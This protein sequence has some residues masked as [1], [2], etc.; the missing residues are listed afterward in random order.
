MLDA[1]S[2][3]IKPGKER[4]FGIKKT[5]QMSGREWKYM[6]ESGLVEMGSSLMT[7]ILE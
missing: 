2:I 4:I 6:S 1:N 3:S 7:E 5:E